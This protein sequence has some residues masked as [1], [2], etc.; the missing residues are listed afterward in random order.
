MLYYWVIVE[1]RRGMSLSLLCFVLSWFLISLCFFLFFF[2]LFFGFHGVQAG[3][4]MVMGQSFFGFV[5]LV[6]IPFCFFFSFSFILFFSQF[7]W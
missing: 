4:N 7:F 2:F 6:Y 1:N 5:H 3:F